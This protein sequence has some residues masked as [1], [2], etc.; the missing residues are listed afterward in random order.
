MILYADK[1]SRIPVMG[2]KEKEA[3]KKNFFVPLVVIIILFVFTLEMVARIFMT[4]YETVKDW[5]A[6]HP[7]IGYTII[8]C[9]HKKINGVEYSI[10]SFGL[11][12]KEYSFKK[13]NYRIIALGDSITMGYGVALE[14]S[15]TKKLEAIINFD[16]KRRVEILN[17]GVP[18]YNTKMEYM[19]LKEIG[20]EFDSDMV[21]LIYTLND[22]FSYPE[23]ILFKLPLPVVKVIE[24]IHNHSCLVQYLRCRLKDA[25]KQ[26]G[27]SD[28][29]SLFSDKNILWQENK[30][31]IREIASLCK[32]KDN[33]LIF[34][35]YPHSI[36]SWNIYALKNVCV[37]IQEFA[38]SQGIPTLNL[39]PCFEKVMMEN[40]V[41]LGEDDPHLNSQ[42][43]EIVAKAVYDF[44][45]RNNI[46]PRSII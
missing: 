42:G 33:K 15:F 26:K 14:D 37:S 23:S 17:F 5:Y 31:Y 16:N 30:Q 9:L 20:L 29:D 38:E 36:G 19:L 10:N 27:Y 4:R 34:V 22:I 46:L 6:F 40:K 18:G 8:P 44:I 21:I 24:K 1:K 32:N 43:H 25:V 12:D 35:I 3:S 7:D 13:N 28:P 41:T 45:I 39:F 2:K 11:R